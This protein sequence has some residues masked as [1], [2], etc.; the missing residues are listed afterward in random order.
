MTSISGIDKLVL[1]KKLWESSEPAI[2]FEQHRMNRPFWNEEAANKAYMNE[3]YESI[4]DFFESPSDRG[5]IGEEYL[6]EAESVGSRVKLAAELLTGGELTHPEEAAKIVVGETTTAEAEKTTVINYTKKLYNATPEQ[7]SQMGPHILRQMFFFGATDGEGVALEALTASRSIT[8]RSVMLKKLGFQEHHII[9]PKNTLT[10]NHELLA[11]AHFN[12]ESR[13]NKIFLPV[14]K[15]LHPTRSIHL[16]RHTIAAISNVQRKMD[17]IIETGKS[18]GWS[19]VEYQT[20]L[21]SMVGDL[22]IELKLGNIALNKNMR[23]WSN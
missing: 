8:R 7:L 18:L 3:E 4:K 22:R 6:H 11:L 5:R 15:A 14:D 1:L 9:S 10:D 19:K 17:E 12:L 23:L 16:G 20:E 13:V 21:R 2:F